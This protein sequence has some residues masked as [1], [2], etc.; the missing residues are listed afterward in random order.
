MVRLLF[1]MAPTDTLSSMTTTAHDILI[2]PWLLSDSAAIGQILAQGWKQ[3]YSGFMPDEEL[4]PRIDPEKRRIEIEDWLSTDFD[5]NRELLLVAECDARVVGFVGART[6]DRDGLGAA[7]K[8]PLLY[9]ASDMQRRGIGRQLLREAA[10][11]LN[12][13]APGP[14]VVSAFEQNPFRR[15]YDA[16][17]GQVAKRIDV[18]VGAHSWPVVLYLWPSAEALQN[19]V[20][21]PGIA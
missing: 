5:P 12:S 4:G 17:G 11:W 13:T 18:K 9:I 3:A 15:F 16:I 21:S 7:G 6:G 8:I 19:G 1:H 10:Q 14:V 20:G 2:R